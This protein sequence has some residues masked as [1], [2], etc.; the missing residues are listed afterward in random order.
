MNSLSPSPVSRREFLRRS[1]IGA[2]GVVFGF[3]RAGAVRAEGARKIPF[4]VQLYSLREQC[5]TDLPGMIA[6]V[7]RIGFKGVEF[8]GYFGHDAKELRQVLDDHGI[9]ACGTHAPFETV[10]GDK[11][12]A[13]IEFN[14]TI[15]N[16][17]IIIPW[18]EGKNKT[19]LARPG[20]NLQ[21]HRLPVETGGPVPWL[22]FPQ[23]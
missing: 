15:G 16:K 20:G 17:F 21:R 23:A 3:G 8:A 14:H 7:S 1:A 13:A 5:K 9:V 12:K 18:L 4:G 2:V 11:L 19:G 10:Q 6:L 22:P